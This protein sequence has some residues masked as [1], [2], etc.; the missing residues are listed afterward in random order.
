MEAE[1]VEPTLAPGVSDQVVP[2]PG[3]PEEDVEKEANVGQ[4]FFQ[5]FRKLQHKKEKV[6][7][8]IR[9]MH[10]FT[11][12][13]LSMVDPVI[14]GGSSVEVEPAKPET[15][16]HDPQ[17]KDN[18]QVST[19]AKVSTPTKKIKELAI[20]HIGF[21]AHKPNSG[22]SETRAHRP[23]SAPKRMERALPI[24]SESRNQYTPVDTSP[25]TFLGGGFR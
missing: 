13:K 20:A 19:P 15:V 16:K 21:S 18:P 7:A 5:A 6:L 14:E 9:V 12:T 23:I 8:K 22:F 25:R 17:P 24:I 2:P 4:M 11:K 10:F 3:L 1:C